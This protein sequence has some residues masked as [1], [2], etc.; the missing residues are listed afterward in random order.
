VKVVVLPGTFS[1][2]LQTQR[3]PSRVLTLT[4]WSSGKETGRNLGK[5]KR[6]FSRVSVLHFPSGICSELRDYSQ[7]RSP[8]FSLTFSSVTSCSVF[9]FQRRT[10]LGIPPTPFSLLLFFTTKNFKVYGNLGIQKCQNRRLLLNVTSIWFPHSGRSH[11]SSVSFPFSLSL[12][13]CV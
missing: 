9:P 7:S 4:G 12:S 10:V 8:V 6:T 3:P 5:V 13:P 1:S 2:E 11:A